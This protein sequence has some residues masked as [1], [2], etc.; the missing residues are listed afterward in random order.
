MFTELLF[1]VSSVL[2][3]LL[4]KSRRSRIFI[5]VLYSLLL[6]WFIFSVLNYGK[7][8]LQAGQSVNLRVNPRTQDLE[9]YSIFILK[10]ND[11]SRIKSTGS[12]VWSERN[13]DV[14]YEV[15]GQKIIKNHGLDEEDEELPNSQPDIYLVKDGVVVSYQGEKVFDATYNKP[16]TITI[17][18]VDNQPAQFEAQVVDK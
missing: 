11:S 1:I 10:K 5:G 8:T 13:S 4:F 17:T 9:Y 3:L 15:E 6:V 7:Y 12:G 18:N 14:Y 16:Y 2:L